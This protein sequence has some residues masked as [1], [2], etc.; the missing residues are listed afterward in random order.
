MRG[1]EPKSPHISTNLVRAWPWCLP[2][3]SRKGWGDSSVVS[4]LLLGVC[5]RSARHPCGWRVVSGVWLA[6]CSG[7]MGSGA[8]DGTQHLWRCS[9]FSQMWSCCIRWH[10]W[11]GFHL[12]ILGT[13]SN[14][15]TVARL[16]L[17]FPCAPWFPRGSGWE[18]NYF[19]GR[20]QAK[21]KQKPLLNLHAQIPFQYL[22][23]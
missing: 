3:S 20:K 1:W 11:A 22:A 10:S 21:M 13:D 5:C 15:C 18:Q 9:R 14:D 7:L 19:L 4:C 17:W 16:C 23:A 8:C 6:G 12:V 2:A